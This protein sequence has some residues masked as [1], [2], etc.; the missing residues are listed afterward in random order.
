MKIKARFDISKKCSSYMSG[1]LGPRVLM[2][3]YIFGDL[4]R[5]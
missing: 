4:P 5:F 3:A 2:N 1:Q